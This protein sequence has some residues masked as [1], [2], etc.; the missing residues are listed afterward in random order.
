MVSTV[1]LL[2]LKQLANGKRSA[3]PNLPPGPWKLP[4]LGSIH[5]LLGTDTSSATLEWATTEL[6]RNTHVMKKA[7]EKVRK[8]LKGN[9][10]VEEKDINKL[11]YLNNVIKETMRVHPADPLLVSRLCRQMLEIGGYTA[12]VGSGVVVNAWPIMRD[13]RWWEDPE[14]FMPRGLKRWKLRTPEER[15]RLT[16]Y[17]SAEGGGFALE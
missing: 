14:R 8:A 2:L 5:Y 15:P 4:I 6:V 7:Q 9:T 16:I 11:S 12:P 3:K 10:N 13:A 17:P 1:L